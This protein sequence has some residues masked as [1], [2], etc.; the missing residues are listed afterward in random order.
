MR[1]CIR[2][3]RRVI[4]GDL[5]RLCELEFKKR[6]QKLRVNFKKEYT[7]RDQLERILETIPGGSATHAEIME[8]AKKLGE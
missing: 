6:V 3:N 5:C 4:L 2:C 8:L 7:K 1:K